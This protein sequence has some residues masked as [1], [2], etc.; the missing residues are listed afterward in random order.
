MLRDPDLR[1]CRPFLV[2]LC[3]FDDRTGTGRS[4]LTW[5]LTGLAERL[6]CA[7]AEVGTQPAFQVHEALS[8]TVCDASTGGRSVSEPVSNGGNRDRN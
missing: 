2:R 8:A 4:F 6:G 3:P 7:D 1:R 5:L